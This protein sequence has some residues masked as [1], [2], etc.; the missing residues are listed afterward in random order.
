YNSMNLKTQFLTFFIIIFSSNQLFAQNLF[1]NGDFE[2]YTTCPTALGQ[3]NNVI[4]IESCTVTPDYYNASCGF[5]TNSPGAEGAY[6]SMNAQA[7]IPSGDGFI[8]F[9][10]GMFNNTSYQF[11]S[12]ILTL[13]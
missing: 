1:S 8:G 7:N 2:N 13:D 12:F 4:G 6:C 9:F 11:E 3:V 10:G 5:L